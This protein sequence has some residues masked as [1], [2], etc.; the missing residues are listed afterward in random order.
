MYAQTKSNVLEQ[1]ARTSVSVALQLQFTLYTKE[2]ACRAQTK[3]NV[4][5]QVARTSVSV[6]LQLQFILYT[7]EAACCAQTKS[8]VLNRL[9]GRQARSTTNSVYTQRG[10]AFFVKQR[11]VHRQTGICF[12][13]KYKNGKNGRNF[14]QIY[15]GQKYLR[16]KTGIWFFQTINGKVRRKLCQNLFWTEIL[17]PQISI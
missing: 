5:E 1:V 9:P 16:L 3:S 2:A 14:C 10:S 11:A 13:P 7:R 4:L 8:N 12:S 17:K 6:A 15:F